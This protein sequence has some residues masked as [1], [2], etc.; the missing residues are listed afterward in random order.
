[1]GGRNVSNFFLL[2]LPRNKRS[3]HKN[4]ALHKELDRHTFSLSEKKKKKKG[5]RKENH[6]R[7][8]KEV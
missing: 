7:Q 6:T 2:L 3:L 1:M 4:I 8:A 5:K